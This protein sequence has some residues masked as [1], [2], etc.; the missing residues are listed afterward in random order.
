LISV[1]DAVYLINYM[2][3]GGPAPAADPN[4]PVIN[5][6]DVNCD[7]ILNLIDIVRLADYL[8]RNPKNAPCNPCLIQQ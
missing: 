5:N 1:L 7:G 6:G 8:F 4:C 2:F 3:R